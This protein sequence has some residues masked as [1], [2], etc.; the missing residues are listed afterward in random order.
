[1]NQGLFSL[2]VV[3]DGWK[4]SLK[5]FRHSV[6]HFLAKSKSNPNNAGAIEQIYVKGVIVSEP[7]R[8]SSLVKMTKKVKA[9]NQSDIK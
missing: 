5:S 1:M 9:S 8:F 4:S 6:G 7:F 2:L 3:I